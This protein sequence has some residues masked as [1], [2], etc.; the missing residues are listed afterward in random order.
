MLIKPQGD[1]FPGSRNGIPLANQQC[2][3]KDGGGGGSVYYIVLQTQE[4][5]F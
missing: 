5:A 2:F 1:L 4:R 3:K